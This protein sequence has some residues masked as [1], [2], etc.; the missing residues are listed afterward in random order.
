MRVP[1]RFRLL[2]Q[3]SIALFV[4]LAVERLPLIAQRLVKGKHRIERGAHALIFAVAVI[5]IVDVVNL[6]R[7]ITSR[8]HHGAPE[9][10]IERSEAFFY[11]DDEVGGWLDQPRQNR[12]WLGCRSY[13]WPANYGA[14]VW[15]GN[16]PQ[17]RPK[18]T[19]KQVLTVANV[20]RTQ[21]TFSFDVDAQ[22]A[23]RVLVNSAHH[24][25]W[26]SSVGTVVDDQTLLAIDV[27]AGQHHV[28]MRY[29]PRLLTPGLWI[30][31]ATAFGLVVFYALRFFFRRRALRRM[32]DTRDRLPR[33]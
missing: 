29:W 5:G 18:P 16:A 26:R 17:A 15:I 8:M 7:D 12:S 2:F 1:S 9:F 6:G 30:S 14:P 22:E 13:E 32:L 33:K 4:A 28:L 3:M 24:R 10:P 20:V 21:N 11:S 27:P 19:E 31:A 23:G 25:G